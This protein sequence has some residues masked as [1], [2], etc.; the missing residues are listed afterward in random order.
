MATGHGVTSRGPLGGRSPRSVGANRR[1][2]ERRRPAAA[3][4]W[5][6]A[7]D[8]LTSG[9]CPARERGESEAKRHT[10]GSLPAGG[11]ASHALAAGAAAWLPPP[12]TDGP[13]HATGRC[14]DSPHAAEPV[15]AVV[16]C[17]AAGGPSGPPGSPWHT[18]RGHRWGAVPPPHWAVAL[19]ASHPS[20]WPGPTATT[21]RDPKARQRSK[22]PAWAAHPTCTGAA[23]GKAP[24]RGTRM[25]SHAVTA[26]RWLPARTLLWGCEGSAL[27]PEQVSAAGCA[28]GGSRA[29]LRPHRA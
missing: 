26:D 13:R 20:R 4:A 19:G 18:P 29:V 17:T 1:R 22:A 25:G 5:G 11:L 16:V 6:N 24:S 8:R 14:Q 21:D 28:H 2:L 15:G 12:K 3:N 9:R 27:H 23:D 7:P 10:P